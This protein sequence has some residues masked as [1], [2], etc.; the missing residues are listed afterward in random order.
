MVMPF[1]VSG[2]AVATKSWKL[3]QGSAVG[4]PAGADS[5]FG[6]SS[7]A[8][9][10]SFRRKVEASA[11]RTHHETDRIGRAKA[12]TNFFTM[13]L[14]KSPVCLRNDVA[15]RDGRCSNVPAVVITS[16]IYCHI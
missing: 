12:I 1:Q 15:T 9:A 3:A 11:A 8:R 14:Q 5:G 6:S 2:Q 13:Q 7:A 4:G 16:A 10:A